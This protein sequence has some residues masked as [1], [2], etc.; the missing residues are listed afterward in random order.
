MT[1]TLFAKII[2]SAMTVLLML[3]LSPPAVAFHKE[4][5]GLYT[6]EGLKHVR[7]P[8][9]R[10][11]SLFTDEAAKEVS[12]RNEEVD[13]TWAS[14][15]YLGLLDNLDF[16]HFDNDTLAHGARVIAAQR[17]AIVDLLV[18]AD[19]ATTEASRNQF[20]KDAREILGIALH[21][22]Q[23]F[24]SHS[25]W[26]DLHAG[27]A[28]FQDDQPF[29]SSIRRAPGEGPNCSCGQPT[30]ESKLTSEYWTVLPTSASAHVVA[31]HCI[32][33]PAV[34]VP[35]VPFCPAAL[36]GLAK[37]LHLIDEHQE[38]ASRA[39]TATTDFVD[40]IIRAASERGVG[41]GICAFGGRSI[42]ECDRDGSKTVQISLGSFTSS[43]VQTSTNFST[44][45]PRFDASLG[46]L[47]AVRF[48]WE[49]TAA[50]GTYFC[51]DDPS[52]V[53]PQYNTCLSFN[54]F[55]VFGVTSPDLGSN[56]TTVLGC[57]VNEAGTATSCGN[58]PAG[59][60]GPLTGTLIGTYDLWPG[61]QY[62]ILHRYT[63]NRRF[64][65]TAALPAG[66]IQRQGDPPDWTLQGYWVYTMIPSIGTSAGSGE[67]SSCSN[68]VGV[69]NY[70]SAT[71]G[72]S[73][74]VIY[75]YVPNL[76]PL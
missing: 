18:Q 63:K 64:A 27:V 68:C 31:G 46:T 61:G 10:A 60:G 53:A 40:S 7:L 34:P 26:I 22:L 23:D 45:I 44:T 73:L 5:H 13:S 24:Y 65:N 75:E 41:V 2:G 48:E 1:H 21:P 59:Y 37:D 42:S 28:R 14:D 4:D 9:D 51:V 38:A 71:A 49:L 11:K 70:L 74:N 55:T 36:Q 8:A 15:T 54:I 12:D 52:A 20:A 62:P 32:H 72:L 58:A 29:P 16:Q 35:G 66:L 3:A 47:I 57:D 39:V 25:N 76:E 67:P 69:F 19:K 30:A 17:Q 43:G 33:G 6:R 50:E 56:A